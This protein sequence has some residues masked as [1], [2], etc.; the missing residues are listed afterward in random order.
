MKRIDKIHHLILDLS[1]KSVDFQMKEN[2][3]F[4]LRQIL[5][6]IEFEIIKYKREKIIIKL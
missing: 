4:T 5:E 3:N 6:E 2:E 1:E